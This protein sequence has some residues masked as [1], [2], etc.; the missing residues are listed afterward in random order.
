MKKRVFPYYGI[1]FWLPSKIAATILTVISLVATSGAA[2]D[3][4]GVETSINPLPVRVAVVIA[5]DPAYTEAERAE[6]PDPQPPTTDG[7]WSEVI[8]ATP[9]G[10]VE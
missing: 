5:A 4:V 8:S 2:V 6:I 3:G 10:T 7:P 9:V 1:L